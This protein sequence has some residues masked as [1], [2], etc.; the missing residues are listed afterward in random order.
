MKIPFI[1][2]F[3]AIGTK[4]AVIA[5]VGPEIWYDAPPKSA[6]TIP[7]KMAVIIPEAPVTPLLTPNAKAK[8]R[9]TAV[10]VRPES[11]SLIKEELL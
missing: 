5:P 10:T 1:P 7:A 3:I 11:M 8:G 4:T 2:Y 6:M 9:A